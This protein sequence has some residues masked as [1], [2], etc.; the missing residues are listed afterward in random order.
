MIADCLFHLLLYSR[1]ALYKIYSYK[2]VMIPYA[3]D[4][5]A[6]QGVLYRQ[7]D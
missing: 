4:R 5:F 1:L 7:E 6:Q 2:I 3:A